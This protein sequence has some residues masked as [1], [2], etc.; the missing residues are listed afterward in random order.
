MNVKEMHYDFKQKLNQVDSQRWRALKAPEIDWKLN[1]AQEVFVKIVAQPR[2]KSQLGFESN[3]RTIDDIRTIVIDQ[4]E[5]EGI[6]PT[7]YDADSYIA[8]LPT[9][10]YFYA[11]S[12]V[13]ATKGN[14]ANI[15]LETREVQHNDANQQS[16]FDKSS[17]EWRK[18][19]IW[20]NKDGI[21]IFT[22]G[23]F[24]INKICLEYLREPRMIYNAEDAVGGTYRTLAGVVLVGTQDCELPRAVHREIVDLAVYITANDLNLPNIVNKQNK[25]ELTNK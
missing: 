11:D 17:F 16:V 5:S 8:I 22:D 12:K 3:Q 7:V 18:A 25:L 6:I 23:T 4:K 14:C 15:R 19:N 24:S 21:R 10:Y 13:F 20:Y 9:D 2:Y 1:E